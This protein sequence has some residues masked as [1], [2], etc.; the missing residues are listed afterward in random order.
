MKKNIV[1]VFVIVLSKA[2]AQSSASAIADSLYALGNYTAS[3]N[4]YAKINSP[5]A[6][7]QIARAYN[8]IGN[9]DKAIAEYENLLQKE[10]ALYR[11]AFELGKLYLKTKK[12]DQALTVFQELTVKDDTN[13]EYYYYLGQTLQKAEK[14]K[15]ASTAHKEAVKRDSTHLRSLFQLGRYYLTQRENDSTLKYVDQGLRFYENDVALINLKALTL[16]NNDQDEEAIPLFERLIELKEEKKYIYEKLANAYYNV[17]DLEKAKAAF[18]RIL[19]FDDGDAE[20]YFG[21]G[22]V[23]WAQKQLDSAEIYIKTSIE[24]QEVLFVEEYKALGKLAKEQGDLKK[25]LAYYQKASDENPENPI[26][27][28]QVCITADQYYKDPKIKLRYY[29]RFKE[30]FGKKKNFFLQFANKRIAELKEEIF[31][32]KEE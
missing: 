6:K 31:Y 5:K 32:A 15:E 7:Q 14:A 30:R 27:Y 8:A 17:G 2:G 9:Y 29:E 21:L 1:I 3:I 4:A 16:Y 12:T 10:T 19:V 18:K 28:Y 20:A 11:A 23:F 26:N 22:D 25:S 24:V 13:P